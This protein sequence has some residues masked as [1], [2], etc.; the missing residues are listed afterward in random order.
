M[1]SVVLPCYNPPPNWEH[2]LVRNYKELFGHIGGTIEIILVN[3]GSSQAVQEESLAYIRTHV[4][5]FRYLTYSLNQ[6]KGFALRLGVGQATGEHVIYTDIDFPYT[7]ESFLAI[8]DALRSGSDIAVGV[9]SKRYYDQVPF[10][11]RRISK[12]LRNLIRV[13]LN[14]PITDTQCGLKG[15]HASRRDIFLSTTINRYLFDLE[16]IHKSFRQKP[17]LKIKAVEI[18]LKP[19][20]VFRQMNYK[21]LAAELN[22]FIKITL[23]RN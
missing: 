22:N 12:I 8:L 1:I 15:F 23:K 5:V 7:T 20:I 10:L 19:G 11:R 21:V 3:D 6:G 18:E 2:T 4:P 17:P 16:F 9:K 13:F 14:L